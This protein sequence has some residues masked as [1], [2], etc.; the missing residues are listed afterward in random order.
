MYSAIRCDSYLPVGG[1]DKEWSCLGK[2]N[3]SSHT[4]IDDSDKSAFD[5]FIELAR[6]KTSIM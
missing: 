6:L 4:L 3:L 2:E 1:N 5:I